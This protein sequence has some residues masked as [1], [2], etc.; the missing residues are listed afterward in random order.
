VNADQFDPPEDKLLRFKCTGCGRFVAE[1]WR[2]AGW[3]TD[4]AR[5]TCWHA[6]PSGAQM[7]RILAQQRRSGRTMTIRL[8]PRNNERAIE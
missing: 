8:H 4:D 6:H 7:D 5:C 3:N 2:N 1:Y